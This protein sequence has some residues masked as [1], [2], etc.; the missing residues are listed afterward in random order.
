[1]T[2]LCA[3]VT[4]GL[5]ACGKRH[6]MKLSGKPECCWSAAAPA[7]SYPRLQTSGSADVVVVGAGIVGLTAAYLLRSAGLSVALLEARRVGRQ[8]TGRS[9][10]KITSQHALIY[11]HLID[12]FSLDTARQYADANRAGCRQISVVGKGPWY[13]LRVRRKR[14]LCLHRRRLAPCRDRERGRRGSQRRFRRRGAC[15]G[16]VAVRDGRCASISA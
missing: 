10:A 2:A 7:T 11:R 4:G 8:V 12:S 14:R 9:T 1:M 5:E 13:R 16:S 15:K 3:Q 6:D